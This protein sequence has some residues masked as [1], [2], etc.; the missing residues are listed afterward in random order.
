MNLHRKHPHLLISIG[1]FL[2]LTIGF[3]ILL[4]LLRL[5]LLTTHHS[6]LD[7]VS[8]SDVLSA[9]LTGARFDL[10]MTAYAL[11]PAV[12]LPLVNRPGYRTFCLVWITC[13]G[14]AFV[15]LGLLELEFYGEFQ[16][17]LNFLV[18]QY[19]KEDPVTV[20]GMIWESFPVVRYLTG[21]LLL[22]GCVFLVTR[23]A[24]ARIP[25]S[26]MTLLALPVVLALFL[27]DAGMARGTL[28]SGPPLRWGDA[29][30]SDNLFLNHLGLNGAYTLAKATMDQVSGNDTSLWKSPDLDQPALALTRQMILTDSEALID[31]DSAAIRR[32]KIAR[33][34]LTPDGTTRSEPNIVIILM[35]SFSGQ[36]VGALGDPGEVTPRFDELSKEG[37]LFTRAFSNGTHTHQG[38]FATLS[39]FPNLPGYEY[40]M[41]SSHGSNHFSG[42]TA[43]LPDYANTFIY[44]GDFNWDN[45]IGFF[46]NQGMDNFIGRYDYRDPVLMDEVWGVSDE[47]MFNRA[48][49]EIDAL[50]AQGSFV[51]VLQTLSNHI[52]YNIPP[53]DNFQPVT[54]RGELS[55]RLTAM[56][57]ADWALGE[58]FD[59]IRNKPYFDNTLFVIVGDHG[60]GTAHQL[61]EINLLRF[62]VPLLFLGPGIPVE[63]RDT[64]IS[65]VDIIPTLIGYSGRS[66]THQ[67]W[68]RDAND[69]QPGDPGLAVIKPSGSEITTAI[70]EGNQVLTFDHERGSHLYEYE[71]MPPRATPRDARSPEQV[72]RLTQRLQ[73]YVATALQSLEE[74]TTDAIR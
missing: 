65:Q 66:L 61:T 38:I 51:A 67:C 46:R 58:F 33:P 74:K 24:L 53:H 72:N 63:R 11:L 19:L 59:Q 42:I 26:G 35:E 40:L 5:L 71:L 22:T 43:L 55:D 6:L 21:W 64:V 20:T 27:A 4:G 25:R 13:F 3:T 50:Q 16:Q 30:N 31:A 23:K 29:Y 9:F 7:D 41:Q 68:G 73:A 15:F 62:H 47:D 39:C 69:L 17:R 52:P 12:L 10:R 1:F 56:K 18:I 8:G 60:F 28:R 37:L 49:E 45:Q 32:H 48:V 2:L 34:S 36:F 54:D 57:Y 70:V 44:N 14:A